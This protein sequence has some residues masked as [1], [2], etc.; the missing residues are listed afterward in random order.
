MMR[1]TGS[2]GVDDRVF[3]DCELSCGVKLAVGWSVVLSL[4]LPLFI[5]VSGI[6][7]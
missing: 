4:P 7:S 2:I 3:C 1:L 6:D 5:A